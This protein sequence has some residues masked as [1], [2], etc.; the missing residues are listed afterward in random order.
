V[1]FVDRNT[2]LLDDYYKHQCADNNNVSGKWFRMFR[3]P[4]S[5]LVE[6]SNKTIMFQIHLEE[7]RPWL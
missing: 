1:E 5:V 7:M 2:F 3:K 4:V 6:K